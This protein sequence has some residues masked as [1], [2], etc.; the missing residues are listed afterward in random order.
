MW[1]TNRHVILRSSVL[2]A[3]LPAAWV[4]A[5][6]RADHTLRIK[7][8]NVDAAGNIVFGF[9]KSI[10]DNVHAMQMTRLGST[11]VVVAISTGEARKNGTLKLHH[12]E[13]PRVRLA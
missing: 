6:R 8:W 1:L 11:H 2:M 9:N 7:S 4:T 12:V 13:V 3:V 10:A 5:V